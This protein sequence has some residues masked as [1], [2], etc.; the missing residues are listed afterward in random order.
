[1][2]TREQQGPGGPRTLG[3]ETREQQGPGDPRTQG[4]EMR[5]QQG[6]GVPGSRADLLLPALEHSWT[7]GGH[8]A[9]GKSPGR[10]PWL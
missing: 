3:V 6:Q 10:G 8:L 4:V 1:M 9:G 5:E 2:E 7:A